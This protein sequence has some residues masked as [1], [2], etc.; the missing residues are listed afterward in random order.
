MVDE[1]VGAF[2]DAID[3]YADDP[4]GYARMV[5]SGFGML[6]LFPWDRSVREYRRVYD[7]VCR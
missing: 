5:H 1:A 2:L 3:L 4:V 6:D 7:L